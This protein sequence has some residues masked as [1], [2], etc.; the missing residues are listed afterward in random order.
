[1]SIRGQDEKGLLRKIKKIEEKA[2][3]SKP[4]DS[5]EIKTETIQAPK[6]PES[7]NKPEVTIPQETKVVAEPEIITADTIQ[8]IKPQEDEIVETT[9]DDTVLK[10]IE[11]EKNEPEQKNSF[12]AEEQPNHEDTKKFNF[13]FSWFHGW[14]K[15]LINWPFENYH[16]IAIPALTYVSANLLI[17]GF[18]SFKQA[19]ELRAMQWN[20]ANKPKAIIQHEVAKF[21]KKEDLGY[22]RAIAKGVSPDVARAEHGDNLKGI[23][24][25]VGKGQFDPKSMKTGEEEKVTEIVTE[26]I[27]KTWKDMAWDV[28]TKPNLD[29]STALY[30]AIKPQ[31]YWVAAAEVAVVATTVG[32][33]INQ[34]E[35]NAYACENFDF[36]SDWGVC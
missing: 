23:D 28:V 29:F 19:A 25:F 21:E 30:L 33:L 18:S 5:S 15:D 32:Y 12:V 24:K 14:G 9:I 2:G 11:E 1:M 8:P 26:F 10:I 4:S 3:E 13:D 22:V 20:E 35:I 36:L 7:Q 31:N 17:N 34:E 16:I 27:A 6:Q